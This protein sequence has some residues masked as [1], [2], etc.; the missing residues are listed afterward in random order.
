MVLGVRYDYFVAIS[1]SSKS[2]THSPFQNPCSIE[3][4]EIGMEP[5]VERPKPEQFEAT[6]DFLTWEQELKGNVL[7]PELLVARERAA[8]LIGSVAVSGLLGGVDHES[9]HVDSQVQSLAEAVK[10]AAEGDDNARKMVEINV[11]T[12]MIER[13]I[14]SGHTTQPIPLNF[15]PQGRLI[16][17]GQ[18]L[19]SVQSNSLKFASNNEIMRQRTEAET[20]NNFLI[21]ELYRTGY[22]DNN[23]L[24]VFSPAENLPEYGFFTDTMSCSI[25]VI[26]KSSTGLELTSMFVSGVTEADGDRHDLEAIARVGD[27]FG[28]DLRG[29][30]PA[31]II[32]NPVPVSR[33]MMPD[34]P[35]SVA[36][37]YDD[38]V[39]HI[40]DV[41]CFFGE[42]GERRDYV[43]FVNIC[44]EREQG[45]S[46]AVELA[47]E[48]L[49]RRH[50]ELQ[51]PQDAVTTLNEINSKLMIERAVTDGTIRPEVFGQQSAYYLLL[52]RSA[53]ENKNYLE[54]DQFITKAKELD[55]SSSCPSG[56][57]NKRDFL[58]GNDS[59]KPDEPCEFVSK[60]CPKCGAKNVKTTVT[61]RE[62]K[63]ACG[64][65]VVNG[66]VVS[67][68]RRQNRHLKNKNRQSDVQ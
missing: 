11:W 65:R 22:F 38:A 3:A 50:K 15:T 1:L 29:K 43:G 64:C 28:V 4:R 32:A 17:F 48:R 31:E 59:N 30:S 7:L 63:G 10:L 5:L 68:R 13:T 24:V 66:K 14:K 25:Q 49:L 61:S 9:S 52:A 46:S 35:V 39:S 20:V 60:R 57:G 45:Y 51:S 53:Y 56:M 54:F 6:R 36:S 12:D 21:E 27:M 44:H 18:T 2:N 37:W 55:Q 67:R 40:L 8:R 19:E 16:Q 34:G 41:D 47:T 26:G 42:P 33:D 58:S 62:I 23:Y